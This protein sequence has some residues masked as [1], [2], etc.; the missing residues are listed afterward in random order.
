MDA[1]TKEKAKEKA[2]EFYKTY[3]SVLGIQHDMQPGPNPYAKA[4]AHACADKLLVEVTG[5]QERTAFFQE[6][7]KELDL[8]TEN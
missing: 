3:K 5:N 4:C 6:V 1:N 2:L 8:M 7:K